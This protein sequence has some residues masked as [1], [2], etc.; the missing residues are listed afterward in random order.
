[1]PPVSG[2]VHSAPRTCTGKREVMG[3][4]RE[5]GEEAGVGFFLDDGDLADDGA[6]AAGHGAPAEVRL[7]PRQRRGRRGEPRRRRW[8]GG[9]DLRVGAVRVLG[10]RRG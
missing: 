7:G 6:G 2:A 1:L 9:M 5:R 4:A 3:Q 8:R 10:F